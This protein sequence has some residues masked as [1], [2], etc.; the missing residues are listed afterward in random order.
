MARIYTIFSILFAVLVF[1]IYLGLATQNTA[2][3]NFHY[4]FG[5]FELPLYILLTLFMV[6]GILLCSFIFLPRFFGLKFKL[7]RIQRALDKKTLE[8]EKQK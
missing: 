3:I 4:Y 8:L 5:S 7:L 2:S 1:F 6:F